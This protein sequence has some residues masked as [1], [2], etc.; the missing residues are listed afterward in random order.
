MLPLWNIVDIQWSL[1][2]WCT[3]QAGEETGSMGNFNTHLFSSWSLTGTNSL[4]C[5]PLILFPILCFNRMLIALICLDEIFLLSIM[6]FLSCSVSIRSGLQNWVSSLSWNS[7]LRLDSKIKIS[8]MCGGVWLNVS[9]CC[10]VTMLA[11]S[12]GGVWLNFSV[13]CS[14]T[15]MI[16]GSVSGV[17]LTFSLRCSVTSVLSGSLIVSF[18]SLIGDK[19]S[20]VNDLFSIFANFSNWL[21]NLSSNDNFLFFSLTVSLF[22]FLY[23][24]FWCWLD[25]I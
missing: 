13:C 11:A 21:L 10:S 20:S 19:G 1:W 5:N 22:F 9:L 14:V 17:G 8:S 2:V 3:W 16:A 15:S 25:K 7:S 18:S 24:W 4:N 6:S 23:D 12:V